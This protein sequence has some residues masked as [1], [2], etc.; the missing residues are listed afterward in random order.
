[1]TPDCVGVSPQFACVTTGTVPAYSV[2]MN[3]TSDQARVLRGAVRRRA[4]YLHAVENT[5]NLS[6]PVN[7]RPTGFGVAES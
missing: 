5:K 1:V 3:I 7:S 2:A 6:R 4:I